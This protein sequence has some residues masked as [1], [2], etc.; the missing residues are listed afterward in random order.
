VTRPSL[1]EK[2]DDRLRT[3]RVMSRLR[4]QKGSNWAWRHRPREPTDF[5]DARGSSR[6]RCPGQCFLELRTD[7]VIELKIQLDIED[8]Q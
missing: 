4:T 7:A 6:P 1:H 8:S 2:P 3:G 5:P